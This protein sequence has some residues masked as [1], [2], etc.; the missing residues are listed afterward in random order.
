MSE[1]SARA[2][3]DPMVVTIRNCNNIREVVTSLLT[4]GSS[5]AIVVPVVTDVS[6]LVSSLPDVPAVAPASSLRGV[7]EA[8]AVA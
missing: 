4:W 1:S 2:D 5:A 6:R 8:D 7:S 3:L